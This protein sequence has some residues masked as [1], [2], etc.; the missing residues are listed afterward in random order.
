MA[1]RLIKSGNAN[2]GIREPRPQMHPNA[3]SHALGISNSNPAQSMFSNPT[4]PNAITP[5]NKCKTTSYRGP[6]GMT[7]FIPVL[8]LLLRRIIIPLVPLMSSTSVVLL[9][10]RDVVF[11]PSISSATSLS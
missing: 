7:P 4:N 10:L 11:L 1:E 9:P 2:P 6:G 5:Y 3:S 8:K